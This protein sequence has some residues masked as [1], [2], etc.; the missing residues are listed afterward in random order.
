MA[1]EVQ[2]NNSTMLR[3]AKFSDFIL[4]NLLNVKLGKLKP[5]G[6]NPIGR[7][8]C[9]RFDAHDRNIF[10]GQRETKVRRVVRGLEN[11][12][13]AR[14]RQPGKGAGKGYFDPADSGYRAISHG[15]EVVR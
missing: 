14:V 11:L 6:L 3:A 10:T 4:S 1:E 2:D 13:A 12:R 15:L 9:F 7:V 5:D 8:A